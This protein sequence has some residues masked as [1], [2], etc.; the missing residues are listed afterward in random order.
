MDETLGDRVVSLVSV[1][2]AM[3]PDTESIRAAEPLLLYLW[4][5]HIYSQSL[6]N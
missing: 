4:E 2:A 1:G 3:S 5:P 6:A